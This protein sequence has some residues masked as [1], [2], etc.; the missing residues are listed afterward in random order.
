MI[1]LVGDLG[2]ARRSSSRDVATVDLLGWSPASTSWSASGSLRR[3]RPRSL[4][5]V[6]LGLVDLGRI[7]VVARSRTSATRSCG[8]GRGDEVK[9][10]HL[11]PVPASAP[12]R[13]GAAGRRP[14][15]RSPPSMSSSSS[16][17]SDHGHHGGRRTATAR[18]PRRRR[19][20]RSDVRPAA[21]RRGTE[22]LV[23]ADGQVGELLLHAH[24]Q[25][26]GLP[27]AVTAQRGELPG[28]LAQLFHSGHDQPNAT[29]TGNGKE[30]GMAPACRIGTAGGT[31]GAVADARMSLPRPFLALPP[32]G[33]RPALPWT[34]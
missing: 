22:H 7:S 2:A 29:R 33:R 23:A 24:R 31:V 10:D 17:S 8:A 16:S 15:R 30:I 9:G 21:H 14:I 19:S 18:R 4:G 32:D 26:H 1:G 28:Q 20:P 5:R 25:A 6:G 27:G 11:G 12:R 3:R 34:V 13:S